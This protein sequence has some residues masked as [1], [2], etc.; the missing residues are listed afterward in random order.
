[1]RSEFICTHGPKLYPKGKSPREEWLDL[2]QI[3]E[4]K[5]HQNVG[6]NSPKNGYPNQGLG[7]SLVNP[8]EGTT[9]LSI[10]VT[11]CS[12]DLGS[13]LQVLSLV[14]QPHSS[15]TTEWERMTV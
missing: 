10:Q 12:L 5:R 2:P 3:R 7:T 11:I 6:S 8:F 15:E 4:K 14:N 9:S 1:M 13:G